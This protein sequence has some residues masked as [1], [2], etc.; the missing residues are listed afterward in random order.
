MDLQGLMALVGDNAEA[1]TFITGMD[2]SSKANVQ[3]INDLEGKLVEYGGTRDKYKQG[4]SLV[5]E[6][7]GLDQLNKESLDEALSKLK[8]GKPDETTLA[9]ITN[10]KTVIE[11]LTNDK[12]TLTS[13]Y[14]SKL[15][16]MALTNDIRDLNIGSMSSTGAAE[17]MILSQLKNGAVRED[18]KIVYKQDGK[19]V[20]NNGVLETPSTRLETMKADENYAPFFK[21]TTKG[22]SNT[23][24]KDGQGNVDVSK[25]N[26]TEMMKQGRNK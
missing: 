3:K 4:N 12:T 10:L 11:T 6:V 23:S 2:E 17:Q 25:L 15:D 7:L 9:E 19:T 1:K 20:Y 24:G 18:G 13:D 14:E 22:G 21:A 5:K 26:P 16:N 8:S